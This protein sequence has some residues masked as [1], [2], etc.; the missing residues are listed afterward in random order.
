MGSLK[1]F[2]TVQFTL[3]D[4]NLMR[5]KDDYA[6]AFKP[7]PEGQLHPSGMGMMPGLP[8]QQM[9]QQQAAPQ[10]GLMVRI[11]ATHSGL[12]TR[13]NGFYLPDKMKKGASSFTD[14]YPKPVLLHHNDHSDNIGRIIAATYRDTSGSVVDL[15]K[16]MVVKDRRG[17]EKGK[18]TEQLIKDFTSGKMPMG[19][20]VDVVTSIL[21][22]SILED[23]SYDGLGYIELVANITDPEAIQKLL[24]GRYLTGSVG[25][26]TNAAICSI[27]RTD[28]TD[29]GQCEHRPGGIYDGAKCFVIAGDL[30]YDEYSFVN[31]PA[32]RHSKVLELNYNGIQD[33]VKTE[34]QFSGRL[35]EAR[36]GFPQYELPIKEENSM[37]IED[38]KKNEEGVKVQDSTVVPSEQPA[39]KTEEVVTTTAPA[40]DAPVADS[41]TEETKVEETVTTTENKT[42]DAK[43]EE[44]KTEEVKTEEVKTEDAKVTTEPPVTTEPVVDEKKVL[45]DKI[46]ALEGTIEELKG[47]LEAQR[48]EYAALSKDF[49][50]LQD[51][52][53][54]AKLDTRKVKESHLQTLRVLRDHE[55]KAQ[56]LST[57]ED[58][59]LDMEIT[60]TLKNVDIVKIADKLGDGMSR[61]PSG[62]V[63]SPNVSPVTAVETQKSVDAAELTRIHEQ[64]LTIRMSKGQTAAEAFLTDMRKKGKLPQ[65]N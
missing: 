26:T 11:A 64:F 7:A 1:I 15:Y 48:K 9:V 32:D 12:I 61:I 20:Q 53:V 14:N 43:T 23:K 25:A 33:N 21:K 58:S 55:V 19:M 29:T 47:R 30:T 17:N 41:K 27:C 24:D 57:L 5:V 35:T 50:A 40:S 28:W 46:S 13:N 62:E 38:A 44:T 60:Q 51:S 3:L 34:K 59:V 18:I 42:E 49:D 52:V 54:K 37:K 4:S 10:A 45:A 31:V 8:G 2:D 36:L 16:D 56:D 39:V 65:D 63:H 22:D 6:G